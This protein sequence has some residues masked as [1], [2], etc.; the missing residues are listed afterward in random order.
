MDAGAVPGH[1][2]V[3]VEEDAAGRRDFETE[4]DMWV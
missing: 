1:M 3:A 2:R 4:L